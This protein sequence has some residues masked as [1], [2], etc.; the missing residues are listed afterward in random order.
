[1]RIVVRLEVEDKLRRHAA[2]E[3]G[4]NGIF[5]SS[6]ELVGIERAA[7][8]ITAF[9]FDGGD[10]PAAIIHAQNQLFG[11]RCFVNIHFA[12]VMTS[13]AQKLLGAA[14]IT[15]PRGCCISL[16]QP[17]V[18]FGKTDPELILLI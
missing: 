12:K 6:D 13:L 16:F 5:N 1:M 7:G 2:I 18:H 9:D 4:F 8:E 10:L 11:I 14:A 3:R 15:A 17:L